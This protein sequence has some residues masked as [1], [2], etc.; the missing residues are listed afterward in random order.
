[1][2]KPIYGNKHLIAKIT[3]RNERNRCNR[4]SL[5]AISIGVSSSKFS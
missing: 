3:Q 5:T 1:M 2:A 4:L